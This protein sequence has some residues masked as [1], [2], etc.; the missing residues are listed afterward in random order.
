MIKFCAV[1][2]DQ[3]QGEIPTYI[4]KFWDG[5]QPPAFWLEEIGV[6][7]GASHQSAAA[8]YWRNG[9]HDMVIYLC[10]LSRQQLKLFSGAL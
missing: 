10:S 2:S 3:W 5:W 9:T 7:A 8:R 1:D 6:P 4:P